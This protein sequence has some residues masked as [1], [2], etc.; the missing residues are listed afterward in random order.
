ML[1]THLLLVVDLR[2]RARDAGAAMG[3]CFVESMK[4]H[5]SDDHP[6]AK[7]LSKEGKEHQAKMEDLD[8]QAADW[9]YLGE[10]PYNIAMLLLISIANNK[11]SSLNEVDLHGLYVKEAIERVEQAVQRAILRCD[12]EIHLVVGQVF[13][14]LDYDLRL[15]FAIGR[16]LHSPGGVSKLRPAIENLMATC[17]AIN[18]GVNDINPEAQISTCGPS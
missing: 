7:E 1:L 9:I 14:Y 16:G 2:K 10:I 17:V 4:A 11:D 3:L 18:R 6:L 8:R 13:I 12:S 15:I 5:D